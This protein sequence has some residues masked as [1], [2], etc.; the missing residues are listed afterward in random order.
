[1]NKI[2]LGGRVLLSFSL[3]ECIQYWT[4]GLND[5]QQK[6]LSVYILYIGNLLLLQCSLADGNLRVYKSYPFICRNI[7]VLI[8]LTY[9]D[10]TAIYILCTIGTLLKPSVVLW[11]YNVSTP[12]VYITKVYPS[13][14]C[15]LQFF[16]SPIVYKFF[17]F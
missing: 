3:A 1:M 5:G 2:S 9:I 15:K 7:N 10:Y 4:D 13:P 11:L 14:H 8:R 17:I 6:V 12:H 16:S